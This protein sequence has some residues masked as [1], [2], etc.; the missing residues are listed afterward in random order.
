MLLRTSA[1]ESGGSV[2]KLQYTQQSLFLGESPGYAF[3]FCASMS[4]ILL[5]RIIHDGSLQN[6]AVGKRDRPALP[7]EV[8]R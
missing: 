4:P 3:V 5:G 1:V 6:L 8:T 2:G 7:R